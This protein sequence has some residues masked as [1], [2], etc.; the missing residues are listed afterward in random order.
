MNLYVFLFFLLVSFV[1][2]KK[3]LKKLFA[4]KTKK[5]DLGYLKT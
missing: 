4:E 2:I 1:D 3:L 5:S